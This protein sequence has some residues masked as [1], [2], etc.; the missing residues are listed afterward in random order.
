[1]PKRKEREP[2]PVEAELPLAK[3]LASTEKRVRDRAIRSLSAFLLHSTS[4]DG[5]VMP[6]VEL[7]KL[8]KGIFYC[9]W[10]SDKPLVQQALADELAELVLSVAGHGADV[11]GDTDKATSA[12]ALTALDFYHGFWTTMATEWHG[13]DKFRLNKYYLLMRRFL[14][15]GLRLLQTYDWDEA[16]VQ[17]FASVMRG[18]DGPL[19]SNNVHMPDSITYHVCDIFLDELEGVVAQAD[20]PPTVPILALLTPFIQLAATSHSKRVYERVMS[21]VV[22]P[23]LDAC[24]AGIKAHKR[25]KDVESYPALLAHIDADDDDDLFDDLDTASQALASVRRAVLKAAFVIASGSDTYTPSR[26]KLY[27]LWQAEEAA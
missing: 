25:N 18:T 27:A 19:V 20:S 26:R 12:R 3:Y 17:R 4:A 24:Q 9:Y 8:W 11:E 13:V 23:F 10:M 1:M 5:L 2:E 14:A 22:T 7:A 21:T 6:P 15:A 16:L